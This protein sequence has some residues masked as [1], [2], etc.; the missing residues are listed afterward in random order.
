LDADDSNKS[1]LV[2]SRD[3]C[4]ASELSA[5]LCSSLQAVSQGCALEQGLTGLLVFAVTG[6][7]TEFHPMPIDCSR[8]DLTHIL[9]PQQQPKARGSQI[10]LESETRSADKVESERSIPLSTDWAKAC[11]SLLRIITRVRA[12][13]VSKTEPATA[14]PQ[15]EGIIRIAQQYNVIHEVQSDFDSLFFGY[16]GAASS[17]S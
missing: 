16:M 10:E 6:S 1:C 14:L 7:K 9:G 4:K 2:D 8:A 11:D 15:I 13:G 17:G 12:H 3:F 5:R